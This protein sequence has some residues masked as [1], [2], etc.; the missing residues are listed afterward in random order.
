MLPNLRD[1]VDASVKA[2][3]LNLHVCHAWWNSAP[4]LGDD[5]QRACIG[6]NLNWQVLT[7]YWQVRNNFGRKMIR[8]TFGF[9][10]G[11]SPEEEAIN[12]TIHCQGIQNL[13]DLPGD[14]T[15]W[16]TFEIVWKQWVKWMA[17][18]NE[19]R[20]GKPL[21]APVPPPV[22]PPQAPTPPPA[23]KPAPTVPETPKP[24]TPAPSWRST[25][26]KVGLALAGVAALLSVASFFVPALAPIAAA[27][28][29]LG[30][31]LQSTGK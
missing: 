29:A 1:P 25:L 26:L 31:L 18:L 2:A 13:K 17:T 8:D 16:G 14:E 20:V 4:L 22:P 23:P 30:T 28:K 9:E 19:V 15:F 7:L 24:T 27:L 21:P 11:G 12:A 10:W 6:T 3:D 5:Y